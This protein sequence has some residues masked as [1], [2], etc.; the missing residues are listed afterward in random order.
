[1]LYIIKGPAK[2]G[3]STIANA[4]R[5]NAISGGHPALL[6][7]DAAGE[8]DPKALVEKLMTGPF[9]PAI[10]SARQPWKKDPVG[11]VGFVVV[12]VG[13]VGEAKLLEVEK[14]VPGFISTFGP[15]TK[16]S[17]AR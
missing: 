16:V 12:A 2:S 11:A 9:D 6:L 14:L 1:M 8:A 3:K 15:T 13:D 7:D 17:L 10:E 4:L 5:N